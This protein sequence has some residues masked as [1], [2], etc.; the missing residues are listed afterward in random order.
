MTA[1]A[2][3]YAAGRLRIHV[4]V[5]SALLTFGRPVSGQLLD[6]PTFI[7]K[8]SDTRLRFW[9][10]DVGARATWSS[11]LSPQAEL[12]VSR[13]VAMKFPFTFAAGARWDAGGAKRDDELRFS[14]RLAATF[15]VRLHRRA[16]D[17]FVFLRVAPGALVER[18]VHPCIEGSVGFA[19]PFAE[20]DDD[21]T[22][23]LPRFWI[24][25]DAGFSFVPGMSGPFGRAVVTM[26]F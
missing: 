26:S 19:L 4:F 10:V 16:R 1:N 9:A 24:A 12:G 5:A 18:E 6:A 7:P 21:P 17:A 23:H 2:D 15:D 8:T 25:P 22:E 13:T 20:M 3:V 14:Q 11:G